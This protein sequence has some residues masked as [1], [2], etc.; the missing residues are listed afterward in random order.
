MKKIISLIVILF[1]V[2]G[3]KTNDPMPEDIAVETGAIS[4]HLHTFIGPNEVDS[5][6]AVNNTDDGRGISLSFAQLYIS[7]IKL[8]KRDGSMYPIQ[9]T[10]ILTN[11]I[12]NVYKLGNVPIGNYKSVTFDVGL[13]SAIN[14][15]VPSGAPVILNDPNMWFTNTAE[16]SNYM[17]MHVTGK[18]DT[19]AAKTGAEEKMAAFVYN[20]G[21]Q[22]RLVHVTMPEQPIA[23]QSGITAYIHVLTDYSELFKGLNLKDINNLSVQTKEDNAGVVAIDIASRIPNMFKYENE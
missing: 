5:Y 11:L 21:T 17:F 14:A 15:A 20:I 8:V 7:N 10:I 22:D 16:A 4:F 3:C 23:V 6:N 13:P 2:L 9:D 18:I 19:S 12:N 1:S